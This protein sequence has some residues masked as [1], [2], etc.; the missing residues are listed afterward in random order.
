MAF[1]VGRGG[2][3]SV[4]G[5]RFE[6]GVGQGRRFR[7][8]RG[9]LLLGGRLLR[10]RLRCGGLLGRRRLLG[11]GPAGGR[12]G[13]AGSGAGAGGSTVVVGGVMLVVA[14]AG[15]VVVGRVVVDRVVVDCSV[16]ASSSPQPAAARARP[17]SI[18]ATANLRTVRR[19]VCCMVFP[20]QRRISRRVR[21]GWAW[22]TRSGY[23]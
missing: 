9:G 2:N 14:D 10:R 13:A 18:A 23:R 15:A 17:V 11:A 8:R 22:W 12:A 7:L 16:D 1:L 19:A 21:R 20:L 4:A 5:A 6:T 3:R